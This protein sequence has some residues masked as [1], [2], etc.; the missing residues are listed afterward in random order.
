[1]T[2]LIIVDVTIV[3]AEVLNLEQANPRLRWRSKIA[4]ISHLLTFLSHK[5][6]DGAETDCTSD[7]FFLIIFNIQLRWRSKIATISHVVALQSHND[8][9]GTATNCTSDKFFLII[10][11]IQY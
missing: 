1:M 3:A 6:E 5:D 8:E 9:D 7:K 10:F 11:N 2:I 4:T